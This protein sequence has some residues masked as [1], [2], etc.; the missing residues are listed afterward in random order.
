MNREKI[1]N[2]GEMENREGEKKEYMK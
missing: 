2:K 1:I